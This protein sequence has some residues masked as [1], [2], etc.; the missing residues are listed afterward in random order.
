MEVARRVESGREQVIGVYQRFLSSE[1][2]VGDSDNSPKRSG[3]MHDGGPIT[4]HMSLAPYRECRG[5][6]LS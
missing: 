1:C 6:K 4:P 2:V 5:R 3:S